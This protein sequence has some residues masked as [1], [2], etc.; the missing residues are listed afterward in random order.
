MH[1]FILNISTHSFYPGCSLTDAEDMQ[2]EYPVIQNT[3]IENEESAYSLLQNLRIK[4]WNRIIV[5]HLN[6]NSVK[7]KTHELADLVTG[8]VDIFY[9]NR[10][11]TIPFPQ[12]N[13]LYLGFQPWSVRRSGGLLLY[14]KNKIPSKLLK[15][16]YCKEIECLTIEFTIGKS[17]WLLFGTYNPRKSMISNHLFC[18]SKSIDNLVAKYENIIIFGDL[19]SEIQEDKMR[20][21]SPTCYKTPQ[22]SCVLI[23]PLRIDRIHFNI[24][25]S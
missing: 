1:D 24:W 15:C 22:N 16:I 6:I 14:I 12:P 8:K 21:L 3:D 5:G 10:K 23:F 18:L 13:L 25:W 19:N 4:N 2:P 11:S 9:L 20:E 17:N 7:N